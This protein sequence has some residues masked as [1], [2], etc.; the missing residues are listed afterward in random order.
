MIVPRSKLLFWV[1]LIVLPFGFLAG[2]ETAT[3]A[4]PRG[5]LGAFVVLVL[6]DAGLA[7]GSLRGISVELP[8]LVRL[9]KDR[10]G[11]IEMRIRNKRQKTK[12]LRVGLA[13]PREIGSPYEDQLLVLPG[14]S[15]L[16]RLRWPC[17]PI[18]RGHYL[19]Q[20][21]LLEGESPF[22]FWSF[23]ATA[24]ARTEIRVY[25]NLA[26][27]RK[28]LTALFLNRRTLGVHVQPQV[29]QGR[30][31]EKLREY[32]P[33]DSYD[34]V[35]WKA[36]AKRGHPVTK[37]F[38]IERTQ[39]IYVIVDASRLSARSISVAAP[40]AA[41]KAR[42]ASNSGAGESEALAANQYDVA[43]LELFVTAA[44]VLGLAAEQQDDLFGLLTFTDRVES[45]VRAKNGRDHYD[46][47]REALYT[48]EPRIV[49]PDFDELGTFLR[50]RLRR[51]AL[52]VFLTALDDPVLAESFVRN[53][54]LICRQHLILVNMVQP[55]RARPLFSDPQVSSLDDLYAHLGGHVLW[56]N[57]R[58]LEKVLHR[59][60]IRFALLNH[61][62]V[63]A[64]LVSQYLTVK[65]RQAL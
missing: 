35:H 3:G 18:K 31:F 48:L 19:I 56:H 62:N 5:A 58:E 37:V 39:E 53:M 20:N 17:R 61:N 50:L 49:T 57:L 22:G 42:P 60:G 44:L 52:L 65:K 27:E 43:T 33:G 9:S 15:E 13:F 14:A 23:R 28:N 26:V 8:A 11:S 24:P 29:G 47:C 4:V 55:V 59:R 2:I 7:A 45:F 51:R 6:I 10:D 21:S 64:Q 30:E 40:A 41:K 54:N 46:A 12:R 34:E 38:Q 32:V 16:S 25:P 1:G 36:T 63:T